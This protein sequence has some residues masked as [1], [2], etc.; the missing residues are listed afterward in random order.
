MTRTFRPPQNKRVTVEPNL[1]HTKRPNNKNFL[2]CF[3]TGT[4]KQEPGRQQ[5]RFIWQQ[6]KNHL[7]VFGS[8]TSLLRVCQAHAIARRLRSM[9]SPSQ[10]IASRRRSMAEKC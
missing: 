6:L 9:A 2:A 5:P 8:K 10:S 1:R 4:S 3:D 7:E